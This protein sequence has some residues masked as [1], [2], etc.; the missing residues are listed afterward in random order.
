MILIFIFGSHLAAFAQTDDDCLACHDDASLSVEKNGKKLSLYVTAK[1]LGNSVHKDLTC[2]SCHED[3]EVKEFPHP[4]GL[5]PV[6]CNKC[7]A[8]PAKLFDAG[9]HGQAKSQFSGPK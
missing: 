4:E 3:A 1:T 9:V 5:K 8:E 7:H 6:S 2:V